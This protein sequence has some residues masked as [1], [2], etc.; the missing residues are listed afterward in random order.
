MTTAPSPRRIGSV[1]R[2]ASVERLQGHDADGRLTTQEFEERMQTALEART[3]KGTESHG[4]D[5]PADEPLWVN[6]LR[7]ISWAAFPIAIAALI[8]FGEFWPMIIAIFIAP[9]GSAIAD[10]FRRRHIEAQRLQQ[11]RKG[12]R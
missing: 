8:I 12:L 10:S 11:Q 1:E 2:D 9:S 6:A 7:L 5:L 4:L 3:E